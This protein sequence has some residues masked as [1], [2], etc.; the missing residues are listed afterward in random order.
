MKAILRVTE[1]FLAILILLPVAMYS[2]AIIWQHAYPPSSSPPK[3]TMRSIKGTIEYMASDGEI[4]GVLS[5]RGIDGLAETLATRLYHE[6][7]LPYVKV[8]VTQ[9]GTGSTA[10]YSL[11]NRAL[12]QGTGS[13]RFSYYLDGE[14]YEIEVTVG[15]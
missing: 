5:T 15:W 9:R 10:E 14:T 4:S 3:P 12:A 13:F 8:V 1:A 2:V 11:G 6:N 7:Q